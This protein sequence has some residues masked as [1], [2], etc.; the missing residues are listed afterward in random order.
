LAEKPVTI[1]LTLF[2]GL[3]CSHD[4]LLRKELVGAVLLLTSLSCY[5]PS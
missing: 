2:L 1:P 5:V 3:F 4:N